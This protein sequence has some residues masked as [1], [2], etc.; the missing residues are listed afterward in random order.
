MAHNNNI[1][2]LN[3]GTTANISVKGAGNIDTTSDTGSILGLKHIKDST[4]S[5]S[6]GL[7]NIDSIGLKNWFAEYVGSLGNFNKPKNENKNI[8]WGDYR[9]ATILGFKIIV[10]NETPNGY[11]N[12]NDASITIVP[13]NGDPTGTEPFRVDMTGRTHQT[14][15]GAGMTFGSFD[16]P[17]NVDIVLTNLN[18]NV[19]ISIKWT[20]AYDGGTPILLATDSVGVPGQSFP[21]TWNSLTGGQRRYNT[22]SKASYLFLGKSHPTRPYGSSYA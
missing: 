9:G 15:A 4:I 17:T 1:G 11:A 3:E 20:S 19:K 13:L 10:Q 14:S 12:A 21:I 18:T 8:K 7:T 6:S 5:D 22:N 16:A 2:K